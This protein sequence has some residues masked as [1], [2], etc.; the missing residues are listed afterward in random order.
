[1]ATLSRPSLIRRQ[2]LAAF[3]VLAYILSWLGF[4]P[5]AA[6]ARGLLP[7]NNIL[8]DILGA[9]GPTFAAILVL[10]ALHGRRGPDPLFARLAIWRVHPAWY[11][12]A[13][14]GG[15]VLVVATLA[16]TALFGPLPADLFASFPLGAL[17]G[18]FLF[19]AVV[20]VWEELGWRGF[21]LPRLQARYDAL[22]A[23]LILGLIW[24]L[25]HLPLFFN[26]TLDFSLAW[27]PIYVANLSLSAVI[28]TWLFNNTRG[29]VL[30]AT[31]YH[32]SENIF[33]RWPLASGLDL[34]QHLLFRLVVSVIVV[35][36]LVAIYG[37]RHLAR[38]PRIAE[39]PR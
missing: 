7:G 31:L 4:I 10:V 35:A 32:A 17:P 1:M 9:A 25:W 22:A 34:G 28:Y 15:A 27:L 16:L 18:A 24:A 8:F 39:P 29:S 33:I 11:V 37:R 14:L 21:A 30:L 3:F 12:V 5:Q 38:N 6:A 19:A 20:A 13:V 2:P 36:L 23:G 26:P